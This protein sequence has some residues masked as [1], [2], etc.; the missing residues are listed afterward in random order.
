MSISLQKN[1]VHA[2]LGACNLGVMHGQYVTVTIVHTIP[3]DCWKAWVVSIIT[4]FGSKTQPDF[5]TDLE[6]RK[7]SS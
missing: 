7:K 2:E 4:S 6:D 5:E 1:T 3:T